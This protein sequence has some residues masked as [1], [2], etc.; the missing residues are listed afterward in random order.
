MDAGSEYGRLLAERDQLIAG[1]VDPAEL[2]VPL[3]PGRGHV[4]GPSPVA[5]ADPEPPATHRAPGPSVR[6]WL[7]QVALARQEGHNRG[8]EAAMALQAE[9]AAAEDPA[10]DP[11]DV[12]AIVA[13][14]LRR[15]DEERV[16]A[17]DKGWTEA[18]ESLQVP[19][20][21]AYSHGYRV[22]WMAAALRLIV[23][24]GKH[25]AWEV[26]VAREALAPP[27][28]PRW[29]GDRPEPTT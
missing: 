12:G 15:V 11:V 29:P 22:G 5:A 13:D 10:P 24:V 18:I 25:D 1:G 26:V 28:A 21:A 19:A 23:A 6:D 9:R 27:K 3:P 8:W 20:T 4:A 17:N 7:D 16:K 14:V 2:V